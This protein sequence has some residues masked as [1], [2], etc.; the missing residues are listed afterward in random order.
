METRANY[1]A[2][3][4]FT[5]LTLLAAFGFV[6]WT[7]RYGD[8]TDRVPLIVTI[9]GSAAGLSRGS[10][11]LFN[12]IRIGEVKVIS[13][14]P[15]NPQLAI[16]QAEVDPLTP[17]KASTRASLTIQGLTGQAYIELTGGSGAEPNLITE[18]RTEPLIIQADPSFFNDIIASARLLLSRTE[19]ILDTLDS[20]ITDLRGPVTQTVKNTET[21]TAALAGRTDEIDA[22]LAGIGDIGEAAKSIAQKADPVLARTE[23]ILNAVEPE[24]VRATLDNVALFTERLANSSNQ[25][26]DIVDEAKLTLEDTRGLV[27]KANE[28]MSRVNDIAGSVAPEDVSKV[29]AD[30][31]AASEQAR[32][33]VDDVSGLTGRVAGRGDDVDRIITN[34][35]EM[36]ARLNTASVRVDGVLAKV[37]ALLGSGEA[38]GLGTELSATLAAYR[39][40][41]DS[42]N[43]RIPAI[44]AGLE[45]FSTS[46]LRDVGRSVSNA[47]RSISRIEEAITDLSRNPQRIITGGSGEVRT[48]DG[49]QRR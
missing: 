18:D 40:L 10:P 22:F 14:D 33:A 11:I 3:G 20:T 29:M 16:A 2:V 26:Q 43:A 25:F 19:G 28:A 39:K 21:F 17:I 27:G 1:V 13:L 6:Y 32:K 12:G 31:K 4:I 36:M 35:D 8:S 15:Q 24:Q 38:N 45:Q 44:A 9:P 48:Y 5:L 41:A 46:G 23:E 34:V 7:A 42:L 37:D 47:E 49:R 30:I